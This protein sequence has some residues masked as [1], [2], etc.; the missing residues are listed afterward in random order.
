[1]TE[2]KEAK[3]QQVPSFAN[4][5][6]M[7]GSANFANLMQQ[8][9]PMAQQLFSGMS[10]GNQRGGNAN[11]SGL[12]QQV[13]PMAQQLFSGAGQQ[14]SQSA[15]GAQEK[16]AE[17]D[18]LSVPSESDEISPPSFSPTSSPIM[19]RKVEEKKPADSKLDLRL[20]NSLELPT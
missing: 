1:M 10:P 8:M 16:Q 19:E 15:S 20:K 13:M 4:Q 5:A 18:E 7:G 12:F 9:M 11:L 17:E 6:Q 2:K 3:E 14:A